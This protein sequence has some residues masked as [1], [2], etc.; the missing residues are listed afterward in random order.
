M[1]L[2]ILKR[3]K[4]EQSGV[5]IIEVLVSGMVLVVASAGLYMSLSAGNR[6]TA[7]ERHRVKANDFAEQELERVRSLRIGDLASWSST[8]RLLEDGTE[9][10]AGTACPVGG[11][12][13]YTITSSTQFLN[14]PAATSTCASGTGSRDF[15]QLNV[16][17]SWTGMG[18]LHPVTASTIISPPSGSLVPNSGSLLVLLADANNNGISGVTLTGSGAGSFTG[19]TGSSGCVLWHN[20]PAG[21]YAMSLSGAVSGLVDQDGNPPPGNTP[22]APQTVSVVD[23]GTNTVNLTYDRPG[24][25][26]GI[27]FRT[28]S[29][30]GSLVTSSADSAVVSA[31]GMTQGRVYGTPGGARQSTFN[32][33]SNLFPFTSPYTVYGGSCSANDPTADASAAGAYGSATVPPGGT[34]TLASPGYVLLPSLLV[35]VH[36][37][38]S[39][40]FPGSPVSSGKITVTELGSPTGCGVTRTLTTSTNSN[41]EVPVA[42]DVG[43]PY[44]TYSVCANNSGGSDKRVI[45]PVD[46]HSTSGT[47][48]DV[49]LNG[50]PKGT[51]P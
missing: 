11:Q 20:L 17:V 36:S 40:L 32:T 23:Q 50:Q 19:T 35:T 10:A 22:T 12:T 24:S 1:H 7:T 6:A 15:L 42:G 2:G 31:S 46:V 14:E 43:L 44:G 38:S 27:N 45:S 51:C 5:T 30:S 3:L 47:T 37:G 41:G 48:L 26:Q 4:A 16:S 28:R 8:R 33:G 18:A 49:Y 39:F 25:I 29:Y 21:N 13:C 9:L 34:A